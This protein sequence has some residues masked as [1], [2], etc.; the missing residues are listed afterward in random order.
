MIAGSMM[1]KTTKKEILR[2]MEATDAPIVLLN[3]DESRANSIGD[4]NNI[5]IR[6]LNNRTARKLFDLVG[7]NGRRWKLWSVFPVEYLMMQLCL[8]LASWRTRQLVRIQF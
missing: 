2:S 1:C 8:M 4:R 6:P 7:M 5:R 3:I